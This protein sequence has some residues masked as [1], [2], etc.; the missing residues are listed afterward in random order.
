[1]ACAFRNTVTVTVN[2]RL[3]IIATLFC[4]HF[5][6]VPTDSQC[7]RPQ[8]VLD[9]ENKSLECVEKDGTFSKISSMVCV[10][11]AIYIA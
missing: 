11:Y 10:S 7:I 2:L 5:M 4:C 1:M 3:L 9:F 8:W 6:F